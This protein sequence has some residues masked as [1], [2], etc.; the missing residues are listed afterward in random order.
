MKKLFWSILGVLIFA[1]GITAQTSEFYVSGPMLGYVEHREALIWLE[2]TAA[3]QRVEVVYFPIGKPT[4]KQTAVVDMSQYLPVQ[5]AVSV[6]IKV[7][8]GPLDMATEYEYEVWLNGKKENFDF[9]THLK[10]KTLWEWR[11]PAPDASF[12]V[13]SCQYINDAPYDR[14]GRPYGAAPDTIYRSM[15]ATASDFIVWGGDNV[16][17]R[18]ADYSSVSG[19]KYRYSYN[20]G[21]PAMQALRASRPNIAIW[22]DHDFGPNDSDA[23]FAS[24]EASLQLFKSYWGNQHFGEVDNPGVY[25]AVRYSDMDLFLMDNRYY[26]SPD[27]VPDSIN[28]KPNPNKAYYGAEQLEWLKNQLQRS[29]AVFKIIVTGGQTLNPI[30]EQE[31]MYDYSA[32]WLSLMQFIGQNKIS[33]VVFVTGDRHHSELLKLQPEGCSYAMYDFTCSPIS[34]GVHTNLGNE[35]NNPYRI[36]GSLLTQHNFGRVS[37][38]GE[39][40]KRNLNLELFDKYGNKKWEYSIPQNNLQPK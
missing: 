12:L 9:V 29:D 27:N 15:L 1:T 26:R 10:T 7:V 36:P 25:S 20:F 37:V 40:G 28:G 23:S 32:E 39:K 18:E 38:K 6:P 14:P 2:V 8:L 13:G 22:D 34:S 30:C 33:G 31:T 11:T 3:C 35:T 21:Y 5:N 24:G 16:Y 4:K 19:M 17:L